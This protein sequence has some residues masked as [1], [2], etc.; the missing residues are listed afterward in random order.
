[1]ARRW[2]EA[3]TLQIW[4]RLD[5]VY[6][7]YNMAKHS[8]WPP[9]HNNT[10]W[11]KQASQKASSRSRGFS[12]Q[13]WGGSGQFARKSISKYETYNFLSSVGGAITITKYWHVVVLRLCLLSHVKFGADWTMYTGVTNHFLLAKH[14][15]LIRDHHHTVHQKL[16]LL[17]TF[18][19]FRWHRQNLKSIRLDLWEKFVKV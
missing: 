14:G 3:G 11:Q 6:S 8:K 10:S 5:N 19:F 16:K 4:G 9:C 7:S 18:H 17:I 2:H 13:I 12:E 1:M 15:N